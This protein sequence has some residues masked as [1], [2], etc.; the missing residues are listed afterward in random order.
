MSKKEIELLLA[1]IEG[2]KSFLENNSIEKFQEEVLK[3]ERFL[4]R[5]GSLAELLSHLEKLEGMAYTVKDFLSI[6]EVAAY[7]RISKSSVYKLTSSR[8]LTVYKPNGKNIFILRSDLNNW[9]KRN[10]TLSNEEI[11]KQAN[12][13][14][15]HMEKE[16]KKKQYQK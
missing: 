5:F 15:Y 1:R 16:N 4:K 13:I 10:P 12:I 14:A 6:D 7:L 2:L 11:E 9:I 8:E 3:V